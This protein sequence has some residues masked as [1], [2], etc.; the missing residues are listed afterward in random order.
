LL[1]FIQLLLQLLLLVPPLL[2]TVQHTVH[3]SLLIHTDISSLHTY[4]RTANAVAVNVQGGD[5][6]ALSVVYDALLTSCIAATLLRSPTALSFST[7]MR[8]TC[9]E[10]MQRKQQQLA[11]ITSC[12]QKP[13]LRMMP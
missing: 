7:S 2:Q 11:P 9:A 5:A 6:C 12:Q 13:E 4:C 10:T 1:L 3:T 8:S